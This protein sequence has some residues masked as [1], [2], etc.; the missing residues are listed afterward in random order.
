MKTLVKLLIVMALAANIFLPGM[1]QASLIGPGAFGAGATIE[2]FEGILPNTPINGTGSLE[3]NNNV[4]IG[5]GAATTFASGV[6]FT[7]PLITGGSFWNGDPFISDFR[8]SSAVTNGW[9]G[10]GNV[11][12]AVVPDGTAWI[13][14]W[15][16]TPFYEGT[17]DLE[18]SFATPVVRA[19]GYV[20]GP[21]G[22]LITMKA[23]DASGNLL[24]TQTIS[25]G[26]VQNWGNNFLGIQVGNTDLIKTVVFSNVD[27]G[28]DKL[29]FES[30]H[31]PLPPSV[32]F[33][34]TGL[35][36][37]LGLRRKLKSANKDAFI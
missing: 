5:N 6:T 34:G 17:R 16:Q 25:P 27:I 1:A 15:Q 33:L 19:G 12:P 22:Y 14:A 29:T 24:D 8:F 26:S 18:F 11:T 7:A 21:A 20:T 10:T 31:A 37:L 23:Y 13:G 2:S 9:S 32:L 30:T 35:L 36:G 28:V 4:T 3:F